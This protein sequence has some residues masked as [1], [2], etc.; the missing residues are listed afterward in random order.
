[1]VFFPNCKINLG[2]NIIAKRADGYHEVVTVF[3][4]IGLKDALEIIHKEPIDTVSQ[5]E[6]QFQSSGLAIKGDPDDNLC[7]KAYKRLQKDF[8]ELPS[9]QMHLHKVIPMGA[10]LGGGSAD[11]AFTLQLLNQYFQL[12]LTKEKLASYALELGSDCPFFIYNKPAFAYG[13]GEKIEELFLDLSA[14]K[15]LIVYPA[16]HIATSWAFANISPKKPTVS[17]LDIVKTPITDWKS[18]LQN[19]FEPAIIEH[20]PEIGEIKTELY[21][22]GAL[23]ASLSGSGSAVY[24]LFQKDC[25]V[26]LSFQNKFRVYEI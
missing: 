13:R 6:I 22:Q 23:Y 8:P 18:N 21:Q 5:G 3:Y 14:Y 20:Y 25:S 17:I 9:V 12:S 11:G 16:I 1:M 26:S 10:G 2:L 15:W 4:P 7:I 19:D 24:G